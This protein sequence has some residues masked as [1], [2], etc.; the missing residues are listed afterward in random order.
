MNS[1]IQEFSR[2]SLLAS[3]STLRQIA[4]GM[5]EPTPLQ[6]IRRTYVRL[7]G[8]ELIYF[9]G[10][11][12]FRLSSHPEVLKAVAVGLKKF[13]LN[14]AASRRTSGNHVAY[15]TLE[16]QLARFYGAEA[17]LVVSTGYLT[18]LAVAQALARHF[19]HA[20]IDEKSHLSP[21]D[22][23]Q[24]FNCP[25]LKFKHRDV[26]SFSRTLQRCG[27][28]AR[29]VVLT[30]GMFSGDGSVAPLRA[31]LKLLPRDGLLIVDDAHGGG[32]IGEHGGGAVEL[33]GVD[34]KRIL[35]CV[36]L[37]KALGCYG[38]AIICSKRLR[39]KIA[40]RSSIFI[41]ST[42]LPLPLAHAATVALNILRRDKSLRRRLNRNVSFMKDSLRRAGM[43]LPD[44]PGPMIQFCLHTAAQNRRLRRALLA[45]GVYPSLIEY[46]GGPAGGYFRF[47]FSSEHTE[48]QL[49]KLIRVLTPFIPLTSAPNA[50]P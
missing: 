18:N 26:E 45:A 17:A 16:R 3:N 14:V 40:Q 34:R 49:R 25:I 9:A 12:Y 30:D 22:A 6:Q 8:R 24:F 48:A 36:T 50:S 7:R 27:R 20:L 11:D 10:C 46:P 13:G 1:Q 41:G 35:T 15:L 42:P 5:I 32:T 39:A 2:Q 28:G 38:G 21:A 37:S 19:S 31:Y 44:A 29:P 23:S 43:H 4:P 33:E 47:V